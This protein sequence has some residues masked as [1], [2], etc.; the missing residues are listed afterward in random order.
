MSRQTIMQ[1][2]LRLMHGNIFCDPTMHLSFNLYL[3]YWCLTSRTECLPSKMHVVRTSL[4]IQ[5]YHHIPCKLTIGS[6]LPN[7]PRF[8]APHHLI[9]LLNGPISITF[10]FLSYFWMRS[11]RSDIEKSPRLPRLRNIF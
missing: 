7:I 2:P 3:R 5:I 11:C 1:A 4:A 8:A 6:F 10:Y 9:G